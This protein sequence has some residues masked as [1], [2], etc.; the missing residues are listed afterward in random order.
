MTNTG[1]DAASSPPS[2]DGVLFLGPAGQSDEIEA[3]YRQLAP[4]VAVGLRLPAQA[5][6]VEFRE[7][8]SL[9]VLRAYRDRGCRHV[10]VAPIVLEEIEH[11]HEAIFAAIEWERVRHP[12]MAVHIATPLGTSPALIQALANRVALAAGNDAGPLDET[13]VLVIGR[14][15][16][17]PAQNAELAKVA[18]LLWEQRGYGWVESGYYSQTEPDVATALARCRRLGARRIIVAP[19]WLHNEQ[20][21][22]R[23]PQ[24]VAQFQQAHPELSII[25]ALPLGNHP[26]VVAALVQ[27]VQ[28]ASG[29]EP[30][31]RRTTHSHSHSHG[32]NGQA[33]SAILPPRY[34]NEKGISA[35][36]MAA[37]PLVYD[38]RGQVAWDRVWGGDDPD[39]PFCEL[40]LAGGPPHRGTLLEPVSASDVMADYGAYAQVLAELTRGIELTT[41]LRT[42]LSATPGWIGVACHSAEMAIWLL[43]AI[44]VE[45]VSVRREGNVL[46]LPAG[47]AFRLEAEIKNV[48]TALAKTHHYWQ[49]HLRG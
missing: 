29:Q 36:P 18:R 17:V 24:L 28:A 5:C 31:Q 19:Y 9:A 40:A 44:V 46:F 37:A 4:A 13:A 22:P 11:L 20:S 6:R 32:Y 49:E 23:L 41:G 3:A 7:R 35:A 1:I 12:Q 27:Q 15:S 2:L 8:P 16:T 34:R 14:G 25:L 39:N 33:A 30:A 43:R 42:Q 48:I 21:G 26:H 47:P 45:N 10:V 38:E